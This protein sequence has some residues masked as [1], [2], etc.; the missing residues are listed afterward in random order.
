VIGSEAYAAY[1]LVPPKAPSRTLAWNVYGKGVESVGRDG[2]PEW[3]DVAAP[4]KDQLLVRVDAV[5]LCFSDVKLIKLGGDHPK[6]YGRDLA[7]EPTRLG[8]ETAVTV[9][10]VGRDLGLRFRPGQRLA[11]QPDIYVDGRS[12]AYGYTIPG[13]LI[14]YHL[15]GPEVL[16]A[17][18]GA[19]VIE[20][21]DQL[22]YAET[23]LTEPWAC[24]EAA[25]TQRRRL[26]PAAGGRAWVIGR[27]DDDRTYDFGV[28]LADAREIVLSG[29]RD[30]VAAAV[31]SSAPRA[32]TVVA[33]RELVNGPFDDI[34]VLGPRSAALVSRASDALAFRGLLNLVGDEPLDGPVDIDIG[35][36]HYHYTAY[37]GTRGP[38]VS[39][40]Y[41]ETRNR[42]ELRSGGVALFVG[43]AGPMGQMHLERALK[44]S[45]G[46]ATL[47]AVDLDRERLAM[48][49]NRLDPIAAALGRRLV[50]T[51]IANEEELAML[52]ARETK[53]RGADDVVVTAPT[54]A[55]VTQAARVMAGDGMLVLFAG[56]P[57]GTRATLDLSRVYLHGAQYTGTSGSRIA[58]QALVVRKT[59][60]GQLSPARAV[61]AVGG[62][63]AAAEGLRSLVEGRFA[64]KI[65]IFPQ[66]RGLPLTALE[67][68]AA[69]DPDLG[70]ALGPG[71][72]WTSEA[73]AI[74]FA[75]HLEPTAITST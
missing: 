11:I 23:A 75:K 9:V 32:A 45:N 63:E 74:L 46:P 34:I 39:A 43:A 54:A 48:A 66:L 53:G 12:T 56:L 29:L 14:G 16:A 64:G 31:R 33:D 40:S 17:D 60:A 35:R 61:A 62:I 38:D 37:V 57:V 28:A 26:R 2:R 52:V 69:S 59:L 4:S 8:H 42:A 13:G 24:V 72:T 10:A 55:A 44:M 51:T 41:G 47:I 27:P 25:Y 49:R 70:A 5:G 58:D 20:V 71:G 21:S 3:V 68:L 50:V 36:I 18:D 73:E 19:Y 67:D 30:D 1:R 7:S 65:V 22:G 15:I 6:L